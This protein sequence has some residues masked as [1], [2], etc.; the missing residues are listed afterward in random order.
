MSGGFRRGLRRCQELVWEEM[1]VNLEFETR[2]L[3]PQG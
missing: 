2:N 1:A 3:R